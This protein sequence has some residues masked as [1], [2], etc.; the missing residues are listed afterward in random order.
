MSFGAIAADYDRLRPTPPAEAVDWLLPD[1]RQVV[2]DLGAGTGKLTRAIGART[3][4]LIAVEPDERMRAV[5]AARSPGAQVLAG[6]GEDI[7]LPDASADAVL[8]ASAWH[9]LAPDL[10]VP[11]IARVLRDG[12]RFGVVWT[13][14]DRSADWLR[15]DE[16]FSEP[17]QLPA[18]G[19]P[20]GYR[21]EAGER[22]VRLPEQAPFFN[23]ETAA[24][25][26][27]RRIPAS[28]LV[29]WLAT[30]SRVIT[31]SAAAQAQGRRRAAAALAEQFPG[32]D[33]IDVP[34]R[35]R[36]WRADR[37]NRAG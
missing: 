30:T 12:G 17:G 8:V 37:V 33:E 35:S 6:R 21:N 31:A 19:L 11:E 26:F 32:A 20:D 4:H 23:T 1:R 7:P 28:D 25:R 34:M 15:I 24:F 22:V 9:W 14:R 13:S 29:E 3:G 18:P 16:W 36:C 10:A 5:L 2:V 27:T